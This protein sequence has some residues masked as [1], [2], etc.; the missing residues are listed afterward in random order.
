LVDAGIAKTVCQNTFFCHI[1]A[2]K[3]FFYRDWNFMV[4]SNK[5]HCIH[6][7]TLAVRASV[8]SLALALFAAAPAVMAQD[9]LL[10]IKPPA[11]TTAPALPTSGAG[12][13]AAKAALAKANAAVLKATA[14]TMPVAI[15]GGATTLKSD[16]ANTFMWEVSSKSTKV[17]LFGTIH[18]GKNSFYPLP[19]VVED[20]FTQ[21]NNLVVEADISTDTTS[22]EAR[23]LVI[24]PPSNNLEKATSPALYARVKAQLVRND[25]APDAV[26]LLKPYMVGGLLSMAEM[27]RLGYDST[28]GVDGYFLEAAHRTK[29]PV[30]ELESQLGQIKMLDS[31]APDLQIAY[32]ENAVLSLESAKTAE[33]IAALVNAWQTGD[34]PKMEAV[35]KQV[36]ALYRL[37][38]AIDEKII[39][40]RNIKMIEKITNF[41]KTEQTY[42][43]AVG[44]LHLVGKRGLLEA[45][46]AKG[47]QVVQR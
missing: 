45:L 43:I 23:K 27:T 1:N 16:N 34:A 38:D 9:G 42:F 6:F 8:L 26:R 29:K 4:S 46:R 14:A 10:P 19:A 25:M 30:I 18:V 20:A 31:L 41:L 47:Y 17:Y 11:T 5:R 28:F 15:A 40:E 21:A 44:A 37:N 22:G 7:R 3:L 36:A 13:D 24:Y 33:N 2:V 12:A 32:L 39:Y 35:A